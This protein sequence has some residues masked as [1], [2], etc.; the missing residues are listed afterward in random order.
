MQVKAIHE[1]VRA[2]QDGKIET[3][4]AGQ[5]FEIDTD[6][7]DGKN[8]LAEFRAAGAISTKKS[9]IRAAK[10][11][12]ADYGAD[13]DDDDDEDDLGGGTSGGNLKTSHVDSTGGDI[14]SNTGGVSEN[15]TQVSGEQARGEAT[16]AGSAGGQSEPTGTLTAA[17][18]KAAAKKAAAKNSS[19]GSD[20]L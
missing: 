17:E 14:V 5:V 11:A 16:G 7:T 20:L 3:V 4:A 1:I 6:T 19:D 10:A 12:A 8:Q 15:T 9:E 18:K 2:N 13:S